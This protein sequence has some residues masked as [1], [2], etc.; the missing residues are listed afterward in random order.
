MIKLN[1]LPDK[2]KKQCSLGKRKSSSG[3][4]KTDLIIILPKECPIKLL[5]KNE[6]R[7][8]I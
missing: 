2:D 6:K 8:Q 7:I 3:F 5:E 4:L 1:S